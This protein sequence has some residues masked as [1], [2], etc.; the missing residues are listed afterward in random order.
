MPA[1]LV[2]G[3]VAVATTP[4]LIASISQADAYAVLISASVAGV[5]IGG[6]G[7]TVGTGF[8]CPT[9]TPFTVPITAADPP[10]PIY[11]ITA[12]AATVS[13]AYPA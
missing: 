11:A 13:F 10:F 12:T 8:P 2:T 6:A 7:V 9:N 5:F 1:T 4:Q 3:Q